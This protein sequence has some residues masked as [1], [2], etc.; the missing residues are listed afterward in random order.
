M[1][2]CRHLQK[3]HPAAAHDC[4]ERSSRSKLNK[5]K[6]EEAILQRNGIK[7]GFAR[8]APMS[9]QQRKQHDRRYMLMCVA[10]L[11]PCSTNFGDGF[12]L[13]IGG[14]SPKYTAQQMHHKT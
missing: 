3:Q 11:R 14:F 9:A 6:E 8:V 13:F 12:Q 7:A 5:K 1:L 4:D 10:D 2:A